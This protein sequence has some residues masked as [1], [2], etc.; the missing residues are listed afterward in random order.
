MANNEMDDLFRNLD[1][2]LKNGEDTSD[3]DD[4]STEQPVFNE[5]YTAAL[6]DRVERLAE[7][8][9]AA[10]LPFM[11]AVYYDERPAVNEE[12]EHG[13][14]LSMLCHNHQKTGFC[15]VLAMLMIVKLPHN[16]SHAVIQAAA[17][18]QIMTGLGEMFE[19]LFGGHDEETD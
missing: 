16:F 9:R 1:E 18:W 13:V 8:L 7:D 12:G 3:S 14:K 10:D 5:R 4:E 15:E 6:N 11:L 19:K 2:F 17:N